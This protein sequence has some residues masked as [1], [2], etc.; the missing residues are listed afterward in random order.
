MQGRFG[1]VEPGGKLPDAALI[2]H[3]ILLLHAGAS[4]RG[5]NAKTAVKK[6]LLPHS[7]MQNIVVIDQIIENFPVRLE[8]DGGTRMVRGADDLHFLGD[9]AARK[10]HLIDFPVPMD[11]D[12]QPLRQSVDNTGADAVETAGNLIAA[13]AE[14]TTGVEHCIDNLQ[15]GPS[16]LGLDIHRDTAAI[17]GDGNGVALV[18]G[19]G[20]FRAEARQGFINGVVHDLVN[21]MVQA[22]RGCGADIHTGT[23]PHRFQTLQD[24]NL[25]RVVFLL[26]Q[27]IQFF[28]HAMRS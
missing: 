26:Q 21:Q 16:R 10:F 24:L 19:D 13:A 25:G 7:G 18:D 22:R 9:V 17:I 8:G 1:P 2:V 12:R 23:F 11:L 28:C 27:G 3:G 15:R 6:R 4:V 14:F 5:G 20:N